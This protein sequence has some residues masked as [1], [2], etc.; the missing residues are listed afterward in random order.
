VAH[1]ILYRSHTPNSCGLC[2]SDVAELL[3]RVVQESGVGP[4]LFLIYIDDL[5]RLLKRNGIIA[6]LFAD[7]VK[8][9]LEISR[10]DDTV[11]LQKVLDII[12]TWACDWQ[13][14]VSVSKCNIL[15]IGPSNCKADYY[16]N[17]TK[18]PQTFTSRDLGIKIASDLLP[19]EHINEIVLRA[20]QRANLIIRCFTSGDINLLVKAFIVYVRPILEYNS[21]IWSPYLKKDID[22]IEKNS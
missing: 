14:S 10:S 12:A 13:L 18:I 2:L 21:I 19:M 5:A 8:V 7:D 4:A 1:C 3:S 20:H 15:N 11:R 9:Y 6:R 17:G 16:I 22:A